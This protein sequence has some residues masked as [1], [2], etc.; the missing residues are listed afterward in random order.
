MR[1]AGQGFVIR[2]WIR[3]GLIDLAEFGRRST[4]ENGV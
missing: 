1:S 4:V 3:G 2:V